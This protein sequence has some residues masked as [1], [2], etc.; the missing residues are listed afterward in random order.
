[1]APQTRPLPP[2]QAQSR[3]AAASHASWARTV[4]R[5]ARTAPARAARWAKYLEQA[6]ELQGPDATDEQV[7]RA[8]DHLYRADLARMR[9]RAAQARSAKAKARKGAA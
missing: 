4:D 7:E 2:E 5:A 8:A 3:A 6:R 1:L 9:L